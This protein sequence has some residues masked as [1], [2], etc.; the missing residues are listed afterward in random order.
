[1]YGLISPMWRLA[2]DGLAAWQQVV[3]RGR[4][5]GV[6][7]QGRE[8]REGG[9]TRRWLKV[10]QADRTVAED[11]WRRRMSAAPPTR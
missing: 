2:P 8:Q 5:R 6:L 7:G 11:G 4:V 3:E 10:K 1:M 9:A